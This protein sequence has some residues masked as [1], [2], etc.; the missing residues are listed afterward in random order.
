MSTLANATLY[1]VTQAWDNQWGKPFDLEEPAC[2]STGVPENV[3]EMQSKVLKGSQLRDVS[4][5][6]Y[7]LHCVT[8]VSGLFSQDIIYSSCYRGCLAKQLIE[9]F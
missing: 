4:R 7:N 8:R 3:C 1:F 5:S 9:Q 2:T 6:D